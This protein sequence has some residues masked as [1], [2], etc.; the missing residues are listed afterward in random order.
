[1]RRYDRFWF[2]IFAVGVLFLCLIVLRPILAAQDETLIGGQAPSKTVG[3]IFNPIANFFTGAF[4]IVSNVV[5][6]ISD[7]AW[8]KSQFLNIFSTVD[9]W[10][11]GITGLYVADLLKEIGNLLVNIFNLI[12]DFAK[13][14]WPF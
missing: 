10:V 7:F 9:G 4:N 8:L 3:E 14:V 2:L 6:R 13:K 12:I 5:E 1:M 11:H